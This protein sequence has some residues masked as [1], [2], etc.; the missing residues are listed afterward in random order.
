[1]GLLSLGYRFAV[2]SQDD[3]VVERADEGNDTDDGQGCEALG[4][5]RALFAS[6][7][8]F[9]REVLLRQRYFFAE[10]VGPRLEAQGLAW[11][12]HQMYMP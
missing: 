2:G 1:V 3:Q 7:N 5:G 4:C 9:V 8:S 11:N 10:E 12:N 6:W